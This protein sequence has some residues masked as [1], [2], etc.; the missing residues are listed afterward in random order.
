MDTMIIC[1]DLDGT[2]VN[3]EKWI[4]RALQETTKRYGLKINKKEF[5]KHWGMSMHVILKKKFP[6]LKEED[7]DSVVNEFHET[8]KR[9]IY[10]IKPFRNT[11][12]ILNQLSKKHKLAIVSNNP[13]EMI[14]K[15]LK[16]T[17]IDKKL[18]KAIVGDNEVRKPKPFPNEIYKAERKIGK[19]GKFMVGDTLQDIKAAKAA[20]VKSVIILTGPKSTWKKLKGADFTIKDI[21]QL[22]AII[23]EAEC[24]NT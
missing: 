10:R 14:E 16:Q 20:K 11:K 12:R 6:H 1:F 17:K 22:P 2:L 5:Y 8:R 19:K 24:H 9:T 4:I 18:F 23:K 15:I 3:T 7:I 21:K 13:H